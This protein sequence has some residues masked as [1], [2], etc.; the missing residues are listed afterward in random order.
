MQ[1][2]EPAI[3]IVDG[4]RTPFLKAVAKPNPLSASDLG[5]AAAKPLLARQP[6]SPE[7]IGEVVVGCVAPS[8][9]EVNIARLI[10]LRA[11][12]GYKVP[13]YTVQRNCASGLQAIDSAFLDIAAGRYD[14]VLAG[15]T[16]CMSR[17]PLL[18]DEKMV[19]WLGSLRAAKD[20]KTKLKAL[21]G[22]R[23]Y[24]LKPVISLLKGLTDPIVC[25]SMGQT[26]EILADQFHISRLEMDT[27]SMRSHHLALKAQKEGDFKEI[28]PLYDWEGNVFEFDNGIRPDSSIEKLSRLPAVFE[29][30]FGTVT[31]GNSS[32]VSDG[33]A[34]VILASEEAVKKY[35]LPILGRIVK[36][37]WASLDPSIMGLGPA[38][39]IAKLL[40]ETQLKLSD[41]DYFEINEAFAGQVLACIKAM[42]DETFCKQELG[43]NTA[44]GSIHLDQLNVDGGAIAIGH[45]VGASGA[46][47]VLHLLKILEKKNAKRGIAS[48]CIGGGQGGAILL[49]CGQGV[50]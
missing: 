18:F 12:T 48:L 44:L 8:A 36:T 30:P 4:A 46:R 37:A 40:Q 23:P 17:A 2:N 45:P 34:F 6:F 20:F 32:Q 49:E 39:A 5:V 16:E 19:A 42:E 33:A 24:F 14:L 9:S 10:G 21:A 28:I 3:Y 22:F 31:A 47:L 25:L 43:L 15:G 35:K 26:A 41:I 7:E 1:K 27:F 50:Q 13:A 29:K 11:G 38:H